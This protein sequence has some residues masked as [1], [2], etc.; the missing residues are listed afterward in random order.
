MKIASP[1]P[2][3]G[4]LIAEFPGQTQIWMWREIVHLRE[5]GVPIQIFST[6]RP[7]PRDRARHD[8]A[9]AAEAETIYLWPMSIGRGLKAMLWAA[10]HPLGVMRCIKLGFTLPVDRR[11]AWRTV[12]PLLLP[13]CLL[14]QEASRL[15]VSRL[16]SHTCSN[17]AILCMMVKRLLGIPFSMTLN[18]DLEIWG[19]ALREKF[20]EADFTIAITQRLLDQVR[21]DYPSLAPDQVLLG[22]I[23]VDTRKWVPT[24]RPSDRRE[25][26]TRLLTVARLHFGK[27]HDVL[28]KALK[29]LVDSGADVTL[30]L[31]GDGPERQALEAQASRDG[32]SER[33]Q[34]HGSLGESRIIEAMHN[35]DIFVLASLAEPLGVA[36]ME[37]MAMEVPTIGTAAGGVTE[38][39]THGENGLL[40]PPK[41]PEALA[42]AIRTL[43]QDRVYRARLAGAGRQSIIERFDSRL[44]AATLYQRLFGH[45]P[46]GGCLE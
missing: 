7:P 22:R 44:G 21:R 15:G 24:E 38:I 43:M 27:G 19:G 46:A 28:L 16:H 4:Y 6:R 10:G 36:Y 2:L 40:V 25:G 17:S 29:L 41:D 11:P 1:E 37:A 30:D 34:F 13:A 12:L 3:I 33:V 35:A 26:A 18:A 42:A 23:G 45:P 31:I 20:E 9:A 5:W 14:A 32:L 39:I 8:F